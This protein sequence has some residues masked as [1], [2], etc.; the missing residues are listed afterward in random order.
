MQTRPHTRKYILIHLSAGEEGSLRI[1]D[2]T[3]LASAARG[4]G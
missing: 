4:K 3:E 1:H 2:S